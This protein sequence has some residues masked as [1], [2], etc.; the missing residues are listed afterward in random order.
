M[1]QC[2][3]ICSTGQK[4]TTEINVEQ[5]NK[6]K[7]PQEQLI[8]KYSSSPF[9]PKVIYLQ[10]QIK[11]HLYISKS[12]NKPPNSEGNLAKIKT[13]EESNT[14]QVL[15]TE[16]I[17]SNDKSVSNNNVNIPNNNILITDAFV[18]STSQNNS[19]NNNTTNLIHSNISNSNININNNSNIQITSSSNINNQSQQGNSNCIHSQGT[20]FIPS[21]SVFFKDNPLL[22]NNPFII[23]N[24]NLHSPKD[25]QT[26]GIIKL[27]PIINEDDFVFEG[28]LQN[29][30]ING[31]GIITYHSNNKLI[32]NFR[33]N[34][35]KGVTKI[36]NE[37]ND[38]YVGNFEHNNA[39]GIGYI[40]TSK[41]LFYGG[42]WLNN[43]QHGFG[44]E[45]WT[46]GGGYEGEYIKGNKD[47]IGSLFF[48]QGGLYE[49][50]FTNNE[51]NGIGVFSFAD[52][53]KYYGN[54]KGNRMEGYGII[55][56]PDGKLFEGCFQE[57]K[58]E[59]FGVFYS[60][61]KI[62]VGIWKNSILEGDVIIV[63]GNKVR[64]QYWENGKPLKNLSQCTQI[65]YE[66][67][68][69]EIISHKV[70]IEEPK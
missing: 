47:G 33:D 59:G 37:E 9:F 30:K 64:K 24:H 31:E 55:K 40:K 28:N 26:G 7:K 12:L 35:I 22:T 57:D 27:L 46:K 5:L 8:S 62:Y 51:M 42:Y 56:W 61:R 54:W 39:N 23:N 34:Q 52:G 29:G 38:I 17:S 45:K 4:Y 63:E 53:R 3:V 49:G 6:S 70:E 69:D 68:I 44:Y 48:L 1:G 41:E 10:K 16:N 65:F 25:E 15:K 43:N 66:K 36:I 19:N 20:I 50:A 32:C 18:A 2:A 60:L 13:C 21:I 67:Y 58:K 14:G 11:K